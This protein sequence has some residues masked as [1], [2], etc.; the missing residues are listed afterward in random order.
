MAKQNLPRIDGA[1]EPAQ[2]QQQFTEP[3]RKQ[4]HAPI[5]EGYRSQLIAWSRIEVKQVP[6][7][8]RRLLCKKMCEVQM[9][10]K[11]LSNGQPVTDKRG[12][13]LWLI[14]NALASE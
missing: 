10:G 14:E 1:L 2:Q 12:L 9:A 8:L 3:A 11:T 13:I 6:V 4:E 5:V 7:P